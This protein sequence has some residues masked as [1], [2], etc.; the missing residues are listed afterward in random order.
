MIFGWVIP[1]LVLG[2][3]IFGFRRLLVSARQRTGTDVS[4]RQV[5]QY[6][7]LIGLVLISGTGVSGL[8]GR[9]LDTGRVVAESRTD[10]AR[11]LTFAIVGLPLVYLFIRWT[12]R[13]FAADPQERNGI[14]WQGYLTLTSITTLSLSLTG[15]HDLLSWVIGNDPYRGSAVAG[16][17]VWTLVWWLHWRASQSLRASS[18]RSQSRGVPHLLLGSAVG[19]GLVAVG[20]GGLIGNIIES[21]FNTSGDAV[22]VESTNPLVNS[23][24]NI[25]VGA[26]VW[27]LYWLK[28]GQKLSR[29]LLWYLY[30][31]LAGITASF[32]TVV[33]SVSIAIYDVLVWYFGDVGSKSASEHFLSISHPLGSAAIGVAVWWYHRTLLGTH[34]RNEVRRIY[35]Y[36]VSGVSMIAASLG[37]LMIFVA[38]VES[39]TPSDVVTTSNGANTLIIA[40]TLL[41]VGA[42]IWWFFWGRIQRHTLIDSDEIASPTRRI[43]ILMLFGV[44][45]VAA[46]ISTITS[47][48]FLFDDLLNTQLAWETLRKARFALGILVT[49]GAISGYHWSI[50]RHEKEVAVKRAHAGKFVVLVGPSDGE[51][52]QELQRKIGGRVQLW[53]ADG[54]AGS[55]LVD[56]EAWNLYEVADLIEQT[57]SDEV[58]IL[59]EK[60]K[61]RAIPIHRP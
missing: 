59:N 28:N 9:V 25:V 14:A 40:I 44:A 42:P 26:P 35:E 29:E 3:I 7:I 16:S 2:L 19:L 61:L 37:L 36:I 21:L 57:T 20:V 8:L 38:A 11:N 45:G 52:A 27:Y 10:L 56:G 18:V 46:V 47:V 1:L 6:I 31:F 33:A 22:F 58:M 34:K 15:I 41:L 60:R 30:V 43:F 51:V 53:S 17:L 23:A 55:N 12:T 48:F 24:I 4:I 49:N 39:F 54:A 50:Y 5:F 13:N 32:I